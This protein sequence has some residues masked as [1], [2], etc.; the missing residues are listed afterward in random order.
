MNEQHD[1]MTTAEVCA[2]LRVGRTGF[3]KIRAAKGKPGK[4]GFPPAAMIGR[5]P[6]WRRADVDRWISQR[7]DGS[8][9]ADD[10]DHA[11]RYR[12][13]HWERAAA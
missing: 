10:G 1:L 2:R 3:W 13:G 4:P 6:R 7:F 9:A 5:R 11:V 12:A 8:A